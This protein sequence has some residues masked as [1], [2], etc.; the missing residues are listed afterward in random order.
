LSQSRSSMRDSIRSSALRRQVSLDWAS[1]KVAALTLE[2]KIGQMVI[3]GFPGR[4]CHPEVRSLITQ[5]HIGGVMLTE[6]NISSPV[7]AKSLTEELQALSFPD[8]GLDL[9]ISVDQEGGSISRFRYPATVLPTSMAIAATGTAES[10]ERC[11]RLSAQEMRALGVNL[12]FAPVLDVNSERSNPVIGVRS[13]SD[14]S[15]VVAEF[16][17]VAIDAYQENGLIAAA[18]HFPG[19]GDTSID[20]HLGLPTVF[21]DLEE[22]FST[23]LPPFS[24][25][26]KSGVEMIMTAHVVFPRLSDSGLPAT[27][28][29][30]IV[31]GLLRGRMGFDG[32]IITDALVMDAIAVKHSLEEASIASVEAGADV[33]LM[34]SSLDGQR[35]AYEGLV[36]A[37]KS[38]RLSEERVDQSVRRIVVAKQRLRMR[39]SLLGNIRFADWPVQSHQQIVRDVA[40]KAITLL[41]NRNHLLPIDQDTRRLGI[42]E[43]AEHRFSPVEDARHQGCSIESLVR[44]RRPDTRSALLEAIPVDGTAKVGEVIEQSDT[45]IVATRN[46]HLVESQANVV[47]RL[48]ASGKPT[49]VVALRNP[50][51]LVA[52]PDADCHVV[53]YGDS[54]CL[55][56]AARDLLF[57]EYQPSGR[58][59]VTLPGLYARGYGRQSF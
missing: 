34:L 56:E 21:R 12:N 32:L 15:E 54:P 29:R 18:K 27:L 51:D 17:R 22:L 5:C 19:H 13:F 30:N 55:L 1:K 9:F 3:V 4:E 11:A 24:E 43:F 50:Y 52:F 47:R 37:V 46:A 14:S 28:C 6:D 45:I 8:T 49:V 57:G 59:P 41:R 44:A 42:V 48:I 39:Q 40:R 25:A 23:H 16:G 26:I 33:V 31:S 58:L 36:E 2:Q 38:G 7:Q 35:R 20:S 53:T 10:A